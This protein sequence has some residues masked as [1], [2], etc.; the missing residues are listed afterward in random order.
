MVNFGGQEVKDEGQTRPTLVTKIPF[1]EISQ[2]PSG[3][4]EANLAGACSVLNVHYV[5]TVQTQKVMVKVTGRFGGLPEASF[6]T[7]LGRVVFLFAFML[8]EII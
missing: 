1:G 8:F 6:W 7:R 5:T 2:E 4:F 3:E